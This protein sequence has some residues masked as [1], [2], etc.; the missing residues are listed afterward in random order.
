MRTL[1]SLTLAVFLFIS[2]VHGRRFHHVALVSNTTASTPSSTNLFHSILHD[3]AHHLFTLPGASSNV[4]PHKN[5]WPLDINDITGIFLAAFIILLAASS[6]IGGGAL[7][8][9]LYLIIMRFPTTAAIALSNI[10]IVGGTLVN[11]VINITR[12]HPLFPPPT[13]LINWNLILVME[14]STILGAVLGGYINKVLPAWVTTLALA[15]L[16]TLITERLLKRARALEQQE[17]AAK[18]QLERI[19]EDGSSSADRVG[20]EGV[21]GRRHR[22]R[23]Q[24]DEEEDDDG[25][26][27]LRSQRGEGSS[28]SGDAVKLLSEE[29]NEEDDENTLETPLLVESSPPSPLH[30]EG[31]Q[32]TLDTIEVE[33]E[34]SLWSN[35]LT[36]RAY[37]ALQDHLH[38]PSP[39]PSVRSPDRSPS[40]TRRRFHSTSAARA[41]GSGR[42]RSPSPGAAS[43]T[44]VPAPPTPPPPRPSIP[45]G[46]LSILFLLVGTV[47]AS[48]FA[49]SLF[50]CPS[51]AYWASVVAVVPVAFIVLYSARIYLLKRTA[52]HAAEGGRPEVLDDVH[53]TNKSTVV[54]P[55]ICTFAGVCAGMFGVGGGIVKGPLML[56]MGVLVEVAAATSATMILFTSL[57]A[58]VI[59]ISFGTLPL[60]YGAVMFSVGALFTGVG[61]LLI[62]ILNRKLKTKSLLVW[63]MAAV[64]GLSC[65]VLAIQG[66][67]ATKHAIAKGALWQWGTVCGV[68]TSDDS[69]P[70]L[71]LASFFLKDR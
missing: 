40:P 63:V 48:N 33:S 42:R 9:P 5:L 41:I 2:P 43:I 16:L 65:V 68:N 45:L 4:A 12:L 18:D 19:G 57:S 27:A 7:L 64:M 24:R 10:T 34:I 70:T 11:F 38:H 69:Q 51:I 25:K 49:K 14:P 58:S 61:H 52:A 53:W 21:G 23:D 59:F 1:V 47:I 37:N 31:S 60:H 46:K 71:H 6:G 13:P 29:E 39:S 50:P 56:E 54:Y 36:N 3:A 44:V 32:A 8:V 15:L 28:S 66:S 20:V 26:I 30:R 22:Y 17:R 55:M 35:A 67:I 62:G